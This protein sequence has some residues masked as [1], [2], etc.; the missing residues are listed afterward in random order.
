MRSK[1]TTL[2]VGNTKLGSWC[3]AAKSNGSFL[4]NEVPQDFCFHSIV[5]TILYISPCNMLERRSVS[6]Q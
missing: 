5:L 6:E 3:T 1:D 2:C 4:L